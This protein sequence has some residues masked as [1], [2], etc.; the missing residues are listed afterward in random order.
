MTYPGARSV[1]KAINSDPAATMQAIAQSKQQPPAPV[2][3]HII[4][5]GLRDVIRVEVEQAGQ[6]R[7]AS[8][9]AGRTR[10]ST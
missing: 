8:I 1:V 5:D 4:G 6:R 9:K 7:T 3:V 10:S 2:N